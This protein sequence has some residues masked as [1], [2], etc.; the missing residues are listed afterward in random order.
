MTTLSTDSFGSLAT[1]H[2]AAGCLGCFAGLW[3][4]SALPGPTVAVAFSVSSIESA[5]AASLPPMV[6]TASMVS[7]TAWYGAASWT[8]DAFRLHR[9]QSSQRWS[10]QIRP[11]D[12]S[13]GIADLAFRR[14]DA[15][16]SF[17]AHEG[18]VPISKV[19]C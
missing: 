1:H 19:A 11:V 14:A 15:R 5:L 7:S 8:H 13:D 10:L 17:D 3:H 18:F 12:N 6:L 16:F 2:L 9:L 4:S